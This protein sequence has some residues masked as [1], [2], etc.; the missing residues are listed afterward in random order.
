[1]IA[2]LYITEV[3]RLDRTVVVRGTATIGRDNEND[4]VLETITVSRWHAILFHDAAGLL[5][6][7]LEST[8]GTLVNGVFVQPDEPVRLADGDMIQFGQVVARYTAPPMV[9]IPPRL[10]A[11]R[12]QDGDGQLMP[13]EPALSRPTGRLARRRAQQLVAK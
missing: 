2:Q 5:L 6:A 4:I 11:A 8:N 7:D 1:M 9:E 13:S 3:G 12:S 10:A